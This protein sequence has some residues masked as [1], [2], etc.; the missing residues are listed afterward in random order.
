MFITN[1]NFISRKQ[2]RK[3][4]QNLQNSLTTLWIGG[5]LTN[6]PEISNAAYN[7]LK[8]LKFPRP[9]LN[10]VKKNK[11]QKYF[12]DILHID[13]IPQLLILLTLSLS[14]N[15]IITNE[16]ELLNL[17][18]IRLLTVT[19]TSTVSF[20]YIPWG[21]KN[22]FII[23]HLLILATQLGLKLRYKQFI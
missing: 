3:I 11:I 9:T 6:F 8:L 2:Q 22:R 15:F 10:K 1:T 13:L 21:H 17:P 19:K 5:F 18:I 7:Y 14:Q 12:K 16:C 20:S 23:I 4:K